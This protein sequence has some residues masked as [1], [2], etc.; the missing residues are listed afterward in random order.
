MAFGKV[1]RF[2]AK[3]PPAPDDFKRRI[4]TMDVKPRKLVFG[5]EPVSE[6]TV[7]LECGHAF[8]S[9]IEGKAFSIGAD[10][11]VCPEC[12]KEADAKKEARP[13]SQEGV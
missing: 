4:S 7:R 2:P 5:A 8:T 1:I 11:L 13:A 6:V 10:Q 12:R 3:G 9:M